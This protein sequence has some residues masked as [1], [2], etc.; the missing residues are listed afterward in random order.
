MNGL[1]KHGN[2]RQ[3]GRVVISACMAGWMVMPKAEM[4]GTWEEGKTGVMTTSASKA[5]GFR[6]LRDI[7]VDRHV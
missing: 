1:I 2:G 6:G 3:R 4:E 7:W 5:L